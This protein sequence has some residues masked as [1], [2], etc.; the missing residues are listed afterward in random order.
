MVWDG[1]APESA[2]SSPTACVSGSARR[3]SRTPRSPSTTRTSPPRS[4]DVRGSLVPPPGHVHDR[5]GEPALC[6]AGGCALNS[7]ANGKIFERTPFRRS[8]RPGGGRRCRRRDRRRLRRLAPDRRPA[9]RLR[10]GPRLPRAD[11]RRRRDRGRARPSSRRLRRRRL[12]GP[13]ASTTRTSSAGEVAARIADGEVVGWFQGRM[14]WGPRAL[15]NRSILC[16]PRRADMKASSTPRS[17]AASRSGP[18]PR[19]SCA[20]ASGSGSRPTTTCRSCSRSIPSA[21]EQRARIP[22][23]T[24]VDGSGRLQTVS[25]EQNPRYHRLIEAFEAQT[26]VPMVL[27]T[28]FNENEP[29]VCRPRRRSTASCAPAWTRWCSASTSWRVLEPVQNAMGRSV[30]LRASGE[31]DC[32]RDLPRQARC[33]H[34][35]RSLAADVRASCLHAWLGTLGRQRRDPALWPRDRRSVRPPAGA[36]GARGAWRPCCSGR[37]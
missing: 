22:A 17:S 33:R 19:R 7:V 4:G 34:W 2:A 15:G 1:G 30:L 23:V 28:S 10:D 37:S 24:H 20:S 29:V 25:R 5:T 16:D 27:N 13:A 14:E 26:G 35:R 31:N 21:R 6:L 32:G 8:L 11:L 18:S 36:R 9:A 3:A 12:H